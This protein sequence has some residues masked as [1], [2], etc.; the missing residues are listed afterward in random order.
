M[1]G[2]VSLYCMCARS[3]PWPEKGIRSPGIGDTGAALWVLAAEPGFS[4]RVAS[5]LNHWATSVALVYL[6]LPYAPSSRVYIRKS[7]HY[8]FCNR[9][10]WVQVIKG[11]LGGRWVV[12]HRYSFLF[13]PLNFQVLISCLSFSVSLT[14]VRKSGKLSGFS[15]KTIVF[16]NQF[17]SQ[18][19]MG[20]LNICCT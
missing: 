16:S 12:Q 9:L 20:P 11:H 1:L 17:H 14:M 5:V 10:P 13:F 7:P 18:R 6:F 15:W 2:C 19:R 4:E 8:G 3:P